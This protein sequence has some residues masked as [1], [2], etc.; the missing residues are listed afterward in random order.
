MDSN[1][2]ILNDLYG[3]ESDESE[4]EGSRLSTNENDGYDHISGDGGDELDNFVKLV[5][6]NPDKLE[7]MIELLKKRRQH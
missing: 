2:D 3:P 1:R 4:A 5:D 6:N 7:Q